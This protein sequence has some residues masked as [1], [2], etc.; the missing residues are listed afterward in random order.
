MVHISKEWGKGV[1][2]YLKFLVF[3]SHILVLFSCSNDHE[4]LKGKDFSIL[5][6]VVPVSQELVFEVIK[7]VGNIK[8]F[9][10]VVLY[11]KAT[12]KLVKYFV[13]ENSKVKKGQMVAMIDRDEVGYNY[14][15]SP[16]QSIISGIVGK[17][18]QDVGANIQ[19]TTPIALILNLNEMK[20]L[21]NLPEKYISKIKIE[22]NVEIQV[23]AYPD[24]IFFAAIKKIIP[25]VSVKTRTFPVE[26]HLSNKDHKLLP[27]MFAQLKIIT[28]EL[29]DALVI[30]EEA[31]VF[32]GGETFAFV[33]SE[34]S[35]V[36]K[37][38]ISLGI[39]MPG[40]VQI[41]SGLNV[42]EEV[43]VSGNHKLHDGSPVFVKRLKG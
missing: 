18:Y 25:E 14:Q 15:E 41:L 7:D 36:V 27:G 40:K 10:E 39:R 6:E 21:V 32:S 9:Q 30:P 34:D 28:D 22:Q 2:N 29:P 1:L 38:E 42:D 33:I 35:K 16:V 3:F 43:V 13:S 19:L 12:G 5:V 37:R 26:I 11:S 31:V 8:A 4:K 24:K 20:I 17:T 23:D